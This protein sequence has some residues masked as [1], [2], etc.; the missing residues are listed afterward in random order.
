M[1]TLRTF[2][3]FLRPH[4]VRIVATIVV[5]VVF[6][7]I[8]LIPP[9]VNRYLIDKV[10]APGR[11]DLLLLALALMFA[12]PIL[13]SGFSY[14]SGWLI[15]NLGWRVIT[16]V[17]KA[18]Y[19]RILS[20]EMQYH[21]DR[22]SGA[23]VARLMDDVNRIQRLLTDETTRLLVDIVVFLCCMSYVI[24]VSPWLGLTLIGMISLF[25]AVG[26]FWG[27]RVQL[28]TEDYRTA[29]DA[30]AGRLNETVAG[31]RQVRIYTSE[32]RETDLFV[33]RNAVTVDRQMASRMNSVKLGLSCLGISGYGSTLA[34]LIAGILVV[35]GR[36]TLGEL[37]A[38]NSYIW[39]AIGPAQRLTNI[40]GQ[41]TEAWVSAQ[42]V[43]EVLQTDAEIR[44][45]PGAPPMPRRRGEVE[46]RDVWFSYKED[47]PLFEGLSLRVEPGRT[48]ALVGPTGCGKTTLTSLLM[49]YWD[50]QGGAILID[51]VDI[52]QVELKSLRALFGVV[53]Q[54]PI[55]FEDTLANNVA[56]G[57]PDASRD[58][59]ARA[60][61]VAELSEMVEGLPEG[62]DT[63]IG[64]D[65]V[66]LSV[67]ERQRVAIARAVLTDPLILVMDEATS[68][69][70]SRSESLIQKAMKHVMHNRTSIVIAHRLSTIV[71]ADLIVAMEDGRIRE[72][73]SHEQLMKI[74]DGLY[75]RLYE[76][77]VR[78][79]QEG[80][81][82]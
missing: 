27:R 37:M 1:A 30:V 40:V 80:D 28:A 75:R 41:L 77:L 13:A 61:E 78:Q 43:A 19:E 17:R 60:V 9:Q 82:A 42:R 12:A 52:R 18:M 59:I 33:N 70:D 4:R 15:M 55:I 29:Y 63:R 67:G 24:F 8:S 65:G 73:G 32:S 69:L 74:D 11:W 6:A 79:E 22:S 81:P 62:L 36:M 53:L 10:V 50:V 45:S 44:T 68:A 3:A 47:Q 2:L 39:M 46:F 57:W 20:L 14:V 54:E 66:K 38:T 48:V 64:T 31:V 58:A 5:T 25:A 72:Q 51:G 71:D 7:L 49:R 23:V 35:K 56:Y 26:R 34:V 76:R 16:A 21:S